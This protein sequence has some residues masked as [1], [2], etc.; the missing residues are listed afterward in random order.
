MPWYITFHSVGSRTDHWESSCSYCCGSTTVLEVISKYSSDV[1]LYPSG[2]EGFHSMVP[3]GGV[4]SV[5]HIQSDDAAI[6]LGEAL[7]SLP[8]DGFPGDINHKLNLKWST[9]W[10]PN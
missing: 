4:E 7:P 2:L 9:P 3:Y 6:L 10:K 5:L 1:W 8:L